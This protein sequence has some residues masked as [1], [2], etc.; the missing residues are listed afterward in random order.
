MNSLKEIVK[1]NKS[2]N[3]GATRNAS[4]YT[5]QKN[6]FITTIASHEDVTVREAVATSDCLPR[7]VLV[8]ML[9]NESETSVIR[10]ILLNPNF[11]KN[12]LINFCTNDPRATAFN[13]D[14]ELV[15]YVEKMS[16]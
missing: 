12:A 1:T 3:S 5:K 9:K 13:D 10:A 15:D 4:F 7:K 2:T 6:D 8:E 16:S 11:P 14:E